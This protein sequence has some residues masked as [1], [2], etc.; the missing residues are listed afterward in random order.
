V[1]LQDLSHSSYN[2]IEAAQLEFLT[3]TLLPYI[4]LCECELNRKLGDDKIWI[5]LSEEYLMTTDKNAK[6][7]YIKNLLSTGVICVNEA[8]KMI[9][10]PPIDGG[11]KHFV[12]FTKIEDNTIEG[13]DKKENE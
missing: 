6:A 9:G 13:T 7:N 8:R 3:H 2:T 11:D 4:S 10:L 5:D 1:L 12:A